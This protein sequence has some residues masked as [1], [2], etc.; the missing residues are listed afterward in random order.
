MGFKIRMDRE[1][2]W[3]EDT[4]EGHTQKTKHVIKLQCTQSSDALCPGD[5][6]FASI[7]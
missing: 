2:E 4:I 5:K 7:L 3:W 6:S 1:E